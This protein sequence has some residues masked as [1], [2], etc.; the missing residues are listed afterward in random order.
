MVLGFLSSA[1]E[2]LLAIISQLGYVGIF[3]GMV[4]ESSFFPFPSEVIMI[5]AGALVARGEMSFFIVF[6]MGLLGSLVGALINF[7]LAFYFGRTVINS[8]VSRYGKFIFIT[9]EKM[10]KTDLYFKKHGEV[11]TFV[12]RLIPVVRQLISLPAGF[13]KMNLLK[14]SLYTSLGAGLWVFILTLIG[15][16]FGGDLSSFHKILLT[17]A[18]VLFA[19]LTS[20]IYLLFKKRRKKKRVS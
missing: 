19:L 14:F 15:Y 17:G 7:A 20:I 18:L 1:I 10:K 4:I 3:L 6:L 2:G 13:A 12:G 9:E 11:T 5:P 8:L 16:I